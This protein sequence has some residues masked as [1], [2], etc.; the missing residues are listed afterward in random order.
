MNLLITRTMFWANRTYNAGDLVTVP[1]RG[2]GLALLGSG[3]AVAADPEAA[4][5]FASL[6]EPAPSA[7][8]AAAPSQRTPA[9]DEI[10]RQLKGKK[11][12]TPAR[13]GTLRR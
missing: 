4:A 1:D 3:R 12:T 6:F 13:D 2:L 8:R 10:M 7:A 11:F 5:E 9:C